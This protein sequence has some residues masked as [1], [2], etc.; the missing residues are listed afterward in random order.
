MHKLFT[1]AQKWRDCNDYAMTAV[2]WST[3]DKKV[4][5]KWY[6]KEGNSKSQSC[7]GVLEGNVKVKEDN[8]SCN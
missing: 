4:Q 6:P 2:T 7:R 5:P 8:N 1:T 3:R